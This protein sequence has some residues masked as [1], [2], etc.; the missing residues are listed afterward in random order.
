ME[1][2][3]GIT[4]PVFAL[5]GL[6]I[7]ILTTAAINKGSYKPLVNK[8]FNTIDGL[9][10]YL[11]YFV[12][13]H[14]SLIWFFYLKTGKWQ[15]PPSNLFNQ[16]GQ[17]SVALFFMIT[18]FLFFSKL[19]DAR[20][21]KINWQRLYI[22]RFLRLTPLYIVV[23]LIMSFLVAISTNY[24]INVP[25]YEL[26]ASVSQWLAFTI[27][28]TPDINALSNT[29]ILTAGVTWS[30]PYEWTFYFLLPLIAILLKIP[31]PISIKVS[32]L[33]CLTITLTVFD[34]NMKI[35][36]SFLGGVA[37][38]ILV[39]YE[40]I[41]QFSTTPLATFILICCL[42]FLVLNYSKAYSNIPLILL[43]IAFIIIAAGNTVFGILNYQV[44]RNLGEITYS[45]YLLHGMVLFSTFNL[46]IG[47]DLSKSFSPLEH[48]GIIYIQT[49]I[50]IIIS[51]ISFKLIEMPSIEMTDKL[52]NL[53]YKKDHK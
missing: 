15:A 34:P 9:R 7:A 25:I 35:F 40:A 53:L 23:I 46:L 29:S 14:H 10:G 12:F 4:N 8:R 52:Y 44:S 41:K 26:M 49:P 20:N 50:I 45:I 28:G 42:S 2:D 17:A 19:I 5:I 27:P 39:R 21:K 6:A 11:A 13:L 48:W 36:S 18:A 32:I 22:S 16:F 31:V 37:A 51:H 33:L 1:L 24:S 38:A 47:S 30:L 3:L 43:S